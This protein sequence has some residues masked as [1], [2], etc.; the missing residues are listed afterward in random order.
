[1]GRWVVG[2]G[3]GVKVVERGE[4]EVR[5]KSGRERGGDVQ[6]YRRGGR[7]KLRE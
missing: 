2:D 1:M 6:G 3:C 4:G 7:G 5:T